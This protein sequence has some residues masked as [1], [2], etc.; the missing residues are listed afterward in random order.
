M[1]SHVV[2]VLYGSCFS[3]DSGSAVADG[4]LDALEV[5]LAPVT[6]ELAIEQAYAFSQTALEVCQSTVSIHK[7]K[8]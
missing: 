5:V 4:V 1:L 6:P 2:S 7:L 8:H 3:V